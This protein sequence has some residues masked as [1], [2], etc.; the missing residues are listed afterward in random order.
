V[1]LKPHLG[2]HW[3]GRLVVLMVESNRVVEKVEITIVLAIRIDE[4]PK[5]QQ[6]MENNVCIWG[7]PWKGGSNKQK[8]PAR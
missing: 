8:N 2:H 3:G 1:K 6:R 7:K 4:G 5:K